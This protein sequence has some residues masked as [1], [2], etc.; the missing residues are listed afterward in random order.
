MSLCVLETRADGPAGFHNPST[1]G[2]LLLTC[3]SCDSHTLFDFKTINI[4]NR[5]EFKNNPTQC[6]HFTMKEL[7]PSD[8]QIILVDTQRMSPKHFHSTW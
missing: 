1:H 3:R 5:H 8:V 4:T 7:K 2:L 6:L